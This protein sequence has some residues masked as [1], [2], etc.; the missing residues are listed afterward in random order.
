M[1][2][3]LVAFEFPPFNSGGAH[4]PYRFAQKLP[5]FGIQPLVVT[6]HTSTHDSS[7]DSLHDLQAIEVI[8]TPAPDKQVSPST[9]SLGYHKLL[10]SSADWWRPTLL[11]VLDELMQSRSFDAL[12]VTVPPFSMAD[13]GAEI[14][15]RYSLPLILDMRDHCSLWNITP[16]A[17]YLH[18]RL[19]TR[20]EKKWIQAASTVITVTDQMARDLENYHSIKPKNKVQVIRNAYASQ[21]QATPGENQISISSPSAEKPLR[22]GYVGSF[23]YD[24]YQRGLIFNKWYQKKPY[25]WLQYSPR[26]ED[27]LY[28]SPYYFFRALALARELE[29][30]IVAKVKI[31]LAGRKPDWLDAMAE[32]FGLADNITHHGFLPHAQCLELQAD[33]DLLLS[34]SVKVID[35]YDYCIAGK[36]YEYFAAAKPILA[37]VTEGAQKDIL[38][39][40]GSALLCDPD[41]THESAQQLLSVINGGL[42]LQPNQDFLTSLSS[43][44]TTEQLANVVRSISQGRG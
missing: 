14:S 8:R 37:F 1:N 25:Q 41:N 15:T 24:P 23:Y 2:L 28:R 32:E 11:P 38:E 19:M 35:G 3:L 42:Q 13:L 27:W 6:P 34:T 31:E 22:I 30:D 10:D 7:D 36:T 21:H 40:S 18:Y 33:C 39:Q 29:P 43:E 4:R 5:N 9:L 12:Y 26:K 16:F 17:S 44:V 20:Y